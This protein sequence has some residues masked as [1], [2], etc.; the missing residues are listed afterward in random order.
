MKKLYFIL[1]V[2]L[3]FSISSQAQISVSDHLKYNKL[4]EAY[5]K[6][7]DRIDADGLI[8][9]KNRPESWKQTTN[10]LKKD[11]HKAKTLFDVGRVFKRT[12]A[13]YTNLHAHINLDA[14]YDYNSE[15]RVRSGISFWPEKVDAEGNVTRFILSN[16][17]KEYFVHLQPELRPK[18]EDELLA[19]NGRDMKWWQK[20]NLTFCKF[21]LLSQCQLNIKD[22]FRDEVLN[23]N[24]REPLIVKLKRGSRVFSV[25]VPVYGQSSQNQPQGGANANQETAQAPPPNCN[26]DPARYPDYKLVYEG[27]HAC[28]FENEKLPQVVLLRIGSFNYSRLNYKTDIKDVRIESEKFYTSYWKSRAA[29]TKKLILDLVDNGGGDLVT[30][31]S[32]LFLEQDFQ[33]QWVQFKKTKEFSAL[34]WQKNAFYDDGGKFK[35]LEAWKKSGEWDRLV[36]GKFTPNMPQFCVT[37]DGDCLNEKWKSRHTGFKGQVIMMTNEWCISSC[38]GFA[39]TLKYYLGDQVY[40]VGV[41]ESGD[42]TYSRAYIEGGIDQSKQGF[43]IRVISREPGSK[44]KVS[45]DA[46]FRAAVSASRSTDEKGNVISGIPQKVDLFIPTGWN[47]APDDW[48]SKMVKTISEKILKNEI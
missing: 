34:E 21:P 30:T 28:A 1:S 37:D 11:L 25:Q 40:I 9:R 2:V 24:R 5:L 12:D 45:E 4:Y 3:I 26:L 35:L 33:D 14:K 48:V 18:V 8:P 38:T 17:R 15:G 41:P 29:G 42:S 31:W 43:F 47:E 10:G 16:V 20:N 22:N 39:W 32:A 23:W 27:V 44:A 36:E 46:V 13:A 6:E 7:I 19:I